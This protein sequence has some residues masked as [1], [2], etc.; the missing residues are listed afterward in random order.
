MALPLLAGAILATSSRESPIAC[1]RDHWLL[2]TLTYAQRLASHYQQLLSAALLYLFRQVSRLLS[3]ILHLAPFTSIQAY[4]AAKSVL[5]R[6]VQLS[7]W[8]TWA[9][10][11]SKHTKR[12][13]K[14]IEFEFF[15]L[16]LGGGGNNLFLV[17]FWPGWGILALSAFALSA[18]CAV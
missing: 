7:R 4:Q 1:P 9:L 12:L 15:T 16:I 3:I 18:W 8:A 5:H 2:A 17:I 13:K 6:S 14:K 11:N 10:W